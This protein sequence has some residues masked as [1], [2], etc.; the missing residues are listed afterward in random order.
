MKCGEKSEGRNEPESV[1][2]QNETAPSLRE[3]RSFWYAERDVGDKWR[4]P[5]LGSA[6]PQLCTKHVWKKRKISIIVGF[7]SSNWKKEKKSEG[8]VV[9]LPQGCVYNLSVN[10]SPVEPVSEWQKDQ[11]MGFAPFPSTDSGA[12][13]L[14]AGKHLYPVT[15]SKGKAFTGVSH[16]ESIWKQQ[17]ERAQGYANMGLALGA[18]GQGKIWEWMQ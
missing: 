9:S 18:P 11:E 13:H 4:A 12:F 17:S 3:R 14:N 8:W 2:S 16:V 6:A 10:P 7:D 1:T 5:V 15:T